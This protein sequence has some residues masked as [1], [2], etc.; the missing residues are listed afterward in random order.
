L[1]LALNTMIETA[2][3]DGGARA[4]KCADPKKVWPHRP[5]DLSGCTILR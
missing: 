5:L 2:E 3:K 1:I 4:F